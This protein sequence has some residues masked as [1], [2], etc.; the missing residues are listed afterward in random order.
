M[1]GYEQQMA[2]HRELSGAGEAFKAAAV[3]GLPATDDSAKYSGQPLTA[4]VLGWVVDGEYR[5]TGRVRLGET[6][7]VV[8]DRTNF[9]AEAGGQVGDAGYLSWPGGR[10]TVITFHSLEDRQV[11]E[12]FKRHTVKRESLQQGGEKLIYEEPAVRL[13]TKKPLTATQQ[14][15][16]DNPRARSAKLRAAEREKAA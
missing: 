6:A 7:A 4:R 8:L 12:F 11:K 14:E 5:T 15:L 3:A 16:T 13:L 1:D 2:R 9:Y 10:M